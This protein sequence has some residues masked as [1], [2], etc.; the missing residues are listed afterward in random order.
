V[1]GVGDIAAT[2]SASW[3]TGLLVAQALGYKSVSRVIRKKTQ[4]RE[5]GVLLRNCGATK[6][7]FAGMRIALFWS[8]FE[9]YADVRWTQPT[10]D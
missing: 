10:F 2:A 7:W 3:S 8:T 1:M 5:L 4:G 6:L 9:D